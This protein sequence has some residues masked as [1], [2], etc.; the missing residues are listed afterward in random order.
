MRIADKVGTN[1]VQAGVNK[2]RSEMSNLQNQA[3]TMKRITKPSDDP[4]GLMRTQSSRTER[5][6]GEQF[7][8][9]IN[10][11]KSN[12]DASEQALGDVGEALLRVKEL[13]L[14]QSSDASSNALTRRTSAVEVDQIFSGIVNVANRKFGERF[15]F[16]G[17]QT[18]RGVFA[19]NG[20]YTGDDG[21]IQIE[22]NKGVYMPINLPG[23]MVFLG[24]E[25]DGEAAWKKTKEDALDL[26]KPV[27][28]GPATVEEGK[29]LDVRSSQ[30]EMAKTPD[31]D[32][33]DGLKGVNIFDV[34]KELSIGLRSNDKQTI[35]N[36]L[37][38]ID[39]AIDQVVLARSKLGARSMNVQS[40][41]ESIQK[42]NVDAKV[43]ESNY[44]DAD[45]FELMTD[46]KK[47][48]TA[49]DATLTTSGRLIQPSLLDFLK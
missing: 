25:A 13:A 26:Q 32:P 7:I 22:I 6:I 46:I 42:N 36:T 12:L 4:V 40:T 3:A 5:Y 14:G 37:D 11:A 20:D 41:L 24:R 28:R 9:N 39:T 18:D 29:S 49:L 21:E 45:T 43:L 35:Q 33:T 10:V 27:L 2:T 16:G 19:P 8:K 47:A 48:Q 34:L 1:R 17:Y 30:N 44:E 23:V 31:A 38:R 15:L